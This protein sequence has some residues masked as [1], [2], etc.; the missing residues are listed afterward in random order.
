MKTKQ[1]HLEQ[2]GFTI[3]ELMIA[4]AVLSTIILL[5][6]VIMTS[7]GSL[8]SKGVNQARIQDATRTITD[9]V[10]Q[11]L[12]L[13]GS[14][15]N[16]E[17]GPGGAI[18]ITVHSFCI[19]SGVRYSYVL[20]TKIGSGK[21]T[22][23]AQNSPHVLWRDNNSNNTDVVS[24]ASGDCQPIDVTQPDLSAD[25]G[26][27]ELMS[28]NSRLTD[29]TVSS[30]SPYSVSVGLAYGDFDLLNLNGA[31]TTCKGNTGDQFC[32]TASLATTVVQRMIN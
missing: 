7:I 6:T 3:I 12:K 28:P 11:D 9:Q 19:G 10:A 20:N 1:N 30:T 5:A 15:P 23:G 29:F 26:G 4:T 27:I 14:S 31:N 21:D 24:G 13:N 2:D 8:Y 22:N 25:T 16:S 18:S 17:S 32:A